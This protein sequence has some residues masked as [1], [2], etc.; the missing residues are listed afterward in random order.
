MIHVQVWTGSACARLTDM[1]HAAKRGKL[2]DVVRFNGAPWSHGSHLTPLQQT[3][4][5]YTTAIVLFLRELAPQSDYGGGLVDLPFAD[6]RLSLLE[7][8]QAAR[9]AGVTEMAAL[10]RS[11]RVAR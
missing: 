4:L 10:V 1:T 3:A 2:C 8:V 9:I 7:K 5:D 6:V 11:R